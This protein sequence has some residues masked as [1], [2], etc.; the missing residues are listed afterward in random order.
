MM[1]AKLK[2]LF[3]FRL[4]RGGPGFHIKDTTL[5]GLLFSERNGYDCAIKISKWRIKYLPR[6]HAG[7]SGET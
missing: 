4:W 2:G 7:Q 3:W 5:H 6:Y 1:S